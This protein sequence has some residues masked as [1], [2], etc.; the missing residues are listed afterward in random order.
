MSEEKFERDQNSEVHKELRALGSPLAQIR[1]KNAEDVPEHFWKEQE[2]SIFQKFNSQEKVESNYNIR[3][4]VP[5]LSAVAASIAIGFYV[6]TNGGNFNTAGEDD[7]LENVEL[8]ELEEYILDEAGLLYDSG[9]LNEA[10]L[11]IE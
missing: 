5:W 7:F 10:Y 9:E 3:K 4:F 1:F 6:F 8:S 2:A 11:V